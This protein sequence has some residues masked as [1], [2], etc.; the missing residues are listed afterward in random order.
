MEATLTA[1]TRRFRIP[2]SP[3]A[4]RVTESMQDGVRAVPHDVL[5]ADEDGLKSYQPT[6]SGQLVA[7]FAEYKKR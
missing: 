6:T 4:A 3:I 7:G 5:Y 1:A 2:K